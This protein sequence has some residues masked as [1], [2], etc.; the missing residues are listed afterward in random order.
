MK[1]PNP[2][3]QQAFATIAAH[4]RGQKGGSVKSVKKTRAVKRNVAKARAARWKKVA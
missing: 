3:V 4:F 2:K 1:A